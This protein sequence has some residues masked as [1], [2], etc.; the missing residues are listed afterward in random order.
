MK[1]GDRVEIKKGHK[2]FFE[3]GDKGTLCHQDVDGDWWANFDCRQW[4]DG[5][6]ESCLQAGFCEFK[7]VDD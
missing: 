5:D 3:A 2:G 4:S 7:V 1:I 6:H